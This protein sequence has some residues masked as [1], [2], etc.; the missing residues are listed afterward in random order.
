MRIAVDGRHLAGGRG[1]ARYSRALLDALAE[2][3]PGDELVVVPGGRA[4]FAA[5][6]LTGRPR[7]D[8]MAGGADVVWAPAPAPLAVSRD[9]P[10]VL[11]VHDLSWV[12][13]AGDFTA[14]ERVWHRAM[15]FGSLLARAD[16]VV[17]DVAVVRNSI[18][19]GWGVPPE[20]VVVVPPG[21]GIA[22]VG[23][24]DPPRAGERAGPPYFLAVGA[25]EPRKAPDVLARAFA[26]ARALGLQ[27]ELV[28]AGSGRV[29]VAGDGVRVVTPSDAELPA[30]YAGA[31]AVVQPAWLEGFAFPPV[32]ALAY[33]TPAIVADLPL[34]AET[35]GDGA[36]RFAPGDEEGLAH[37][38]LRLERGPE[39]RTQL[40]RS[41][42]AAIAPLSWQR[43][44]RELRAVFEAVAR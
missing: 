33:G 37:A 44:A 20:R 32:E 31:Q 30:L 8:R 25:L 10:F 29:D 39:L 23:N 35:I 15:R 19:E 24:I 5:A 16:R 13:R 17:C 18:I 28:F 3:F 7:L 21:P 40:V 9:V 11:T 14:Y 26:R 34:Y 1:I 41:G 38:L 42:Q 2:Q 6:A 12:E 22:G 43:A 36:L 27:A 4:A